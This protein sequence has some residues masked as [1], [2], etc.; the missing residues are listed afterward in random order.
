M[1]S[2]NQYKDIRH[3]AEQTYPQRTSASRRQPARAGF[4]HARQVHEC[5]FVLRI[6]AQM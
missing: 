1:L 5:L 6:G 4:L 3:Q 2:A